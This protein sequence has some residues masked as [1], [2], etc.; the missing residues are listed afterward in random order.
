MS[1]Q[2]SAAVTPDVAL[3]G[4][5]SVFRAGVF[6]RHFNANKAN[7][8]RLGNENDNYIELAPSVTLA[9]VDGTEWSFTTAFAMQ[10]QENGAWQSTDDN[11][12]NFAN[13]QV[14]LRVT[15]LLDSD[16]G[17]ALWVGKKYVR[18]DSHLVDIQW[19]DV[20]GNGAGIEN[21]SLGS[22]KLR[23]NWTRRDD[24]LKFTTKA[25]YSTLNGHDEINGDGK[26]AVKAP[27]RTATNMFD[28]EYGFAP[29]DSSWASVG[30]T[31]VAPQRYASEYSNY[32]YKVE[33]EVGNSHLFTA[34]L[35]ESLLGG[36]NN[37]VVRYVKGSTAG[38]GFWQ[39]TYTDSKDSSS[40][41]IDIIDFGTVN[42]TENFNMLYHT[43]FNF[44]KVKNSLDN[45]ETHGRDFQLVLR[46]QYKLT[47]MTRL[48]L[49][50]GMYTS[51]SDTT[52]FGDESERGNTQQ[53]KLT[54]AYGITPDA[55]NVMS[56]PEIRFFAT[57][58]HFGHN[59]GRT[60]TYDHDYTVNLMD[61]A[62]AKASTVD[63]LYTGRKTE[64]YFGAQAEAW[65]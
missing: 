18:S 44:S 30:Y 1:A 58:K 28:V 33:K 17:A 63:S 64:V 20:S 50:A 31:L 13:T 59:E 52:V 42:F 5:S 61:K 55:G 24:S 38:S 9:E 45:K 60:G 36:W 40:Y 8:G 32:G 27:S 49:E 6:S 29:F 12:L 3:K 4:N 48:I 57:Y 56:R 2:A 14:F 41:N 26:K 25:G 10:S 11:N 21:L 62:T 47:K 43:W 23:A 35:G 53:Q 19:R 46:P 51:S 37:T 16:K 65:F 39:H 54:L 34:V 15:G 22:G 7:V